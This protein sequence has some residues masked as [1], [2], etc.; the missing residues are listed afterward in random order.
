MCTAKAFH[1]YFDTNETNFWTTRY[2]T[3]L[4][5]PRYDEFVRLSTASSASASSSASAA[6]AASTSTSFVGWSV[7]QHL[8]WSLWTL[9]YDQPHITPTQ[10]FNVHRN[11]W[12]CIARERKRKTLELLKRKRQIEEYQRQQSLSSLTLASAATAKS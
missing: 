8:I 7:K 10:R 12:V 1:S 9:A 2:I 4:G 3:D 11:I 5:R 6:A